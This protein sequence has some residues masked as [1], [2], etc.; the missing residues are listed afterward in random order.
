LQSLEQAWTRLE[1]EKSIQAIP[2]LK[3]QLAA[4]GVIKLGLNSASPL[5]HRGVLRAINQYGNFQQCG[6]HLFISAQI[7]WKHQPNAGCDAWTISARLR[8]NS[9]EPSRLSR[10]SFAQI[11]IGRSV[12]SDVNKGQYFVQSSE[13][14]TGVTG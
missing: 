2:I 12:L 5:R 13:Q 1:C 11:T 10:P 8:P 14:L 9:K 7:Y 4:E 6:A 3:H